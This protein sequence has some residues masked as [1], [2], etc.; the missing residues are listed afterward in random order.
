MSSQSN[1]SSHFYYPPNPTSYVAVVTI[2]KADAE[3]VTR[4]LGRLYHNE[5]WNSKFVG[6]TSAGPALAVGGVC[7]RTLDRCL[8]QP[9]LKVAPELSQCNVSTLVPD[10]S[11]TSA[12][13]VSISVILHPVRV[14]LPKAHDLGVGFLGDPRPLRKRRVSYLFYFI[15]PS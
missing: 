3:E 7:D 15:G 2:P 14:S 9:E 11:V 12:P 4:T 13:H 1:K 10:R 8:S 5:G 6:C